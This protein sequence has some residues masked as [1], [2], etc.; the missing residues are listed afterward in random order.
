MDPLTQVTFDLRNAF[1]ARMGMSADSTAQR[2]KQLSWKAN[3]QCCAM[4]ASKWSLE[5]SKQSH[6]SSES[7]S[8]SQLNIDGSG[9]IGDTF[10]A[11]K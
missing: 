9:W 8:I 11:V 3:G 4:H 2:E 1:H 7:I 10:D 5:P 6:T